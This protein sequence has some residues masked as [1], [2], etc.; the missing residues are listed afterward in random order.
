M[1]C[2]K[3]QSIFVYIHRIPKYL[4]SAPSKNYKNVE[5]GYL[6]AVSECETVGWRDTGL[7]RW[8]WIW[9]GGAVLLALFSAV[10]CI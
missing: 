3:T 5:R 2:G 4:F 6:K 8:R 7:G 9:N 1:L 10:M